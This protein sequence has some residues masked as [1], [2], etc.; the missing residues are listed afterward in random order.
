MYDNQD[1]VSMRLLNSVIRVGTTPVFVIDITRTE[2]KY[3]SLSS[4]RE[5]IISLKSP[6]L[7]LLPVPLGYIN[8]RAGA[9]YLSRIPQR[10]YKQGLA[11]ESLKM[12][13]MSR[14]KEVLRSKAL[15]R[16]IA[17]EYPNHEEVIRRIKD[18]ENINLAFSRQFAIGEAPTFEGTGGALSL[19]FRGRRVGEVTKKND[20]L[21]LVPRF[22]YLQEKLIG[23]LA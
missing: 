23:V 12:E 18:G 21:K 2:L 13:G 15:A 10:K 5:N 1:N 9:H 16:C 19:L 11:Y 8:Y 3:K 4:G 17:G 20:E 6:R 14:G 7:N 22:I